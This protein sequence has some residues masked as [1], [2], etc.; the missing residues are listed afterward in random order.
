MPPNVSVRAGSPYIIRTY[1]QDIIQLVSLT[2]SER[3]YNPSPGSSI[4]MECQ[5]PVSHYPYISWRHI[6]NCRNGYVASTLWK[7]GLCPSCAV[8]V[9]SKGLHLQIIQHLIANYP[10]VVTGQYF[11]VH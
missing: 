5:P 1:C 2:S 6:I 11:H 8:P 4:P 3:S 9:C 7:G 10:N